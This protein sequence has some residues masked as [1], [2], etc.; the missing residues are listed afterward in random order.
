MGKVKILLVSNPEH[1]MVKTIST[2]YML[3]DDGE[4]KWINENMVFYF[5]E[6]LRTKA[7]QDVLIEKD[8][9]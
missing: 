6:L 9:K 8:T 4:V 1:K 2:V 5:D 3:E 7:F